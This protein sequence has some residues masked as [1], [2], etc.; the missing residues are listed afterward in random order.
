M[1]AGKF[2]MYEKNI[3]KASI[4]EKLAFANKGQLCGKSYGLGFMPRFLLPL[5]QK[6]IARLK[7]LE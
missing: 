5:L 1:M 6:L 3:Q 2:N 4:P 7:N